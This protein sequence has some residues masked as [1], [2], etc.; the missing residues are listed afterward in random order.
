MEKKTCPI[1]MEE[2][3]YP[4]N[5]KCGHEFETVAIEQWLI[6]NNTCPVCRNVEYEIK[7]EETKSFQT[8]DFNTYMRSE[9]PEYAISHITISLGGASVTMSRDELTR[10]TLSL[11]RSSSMLGLPF[12]PEI[13]GSG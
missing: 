4:K 7:K 3:E 11:L 1:S 8:V 6:D 2:M 13:L 5:L 12:N 10:N 9:I